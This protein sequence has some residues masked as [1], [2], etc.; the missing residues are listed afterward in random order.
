MCRC[1]VGTYSSVSVNVFQ[2]MCVFVCI[3]VAVKGDGKERSVKDKG[4][5]QPVYCYVVIAISI[6]LLSLT[7]CTKPQTLASHAQKKAFILLLKLQYID[8]VIDIL[9]LLSPKIFEG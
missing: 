2:H 8:E 3:A 4:T 9:S 5:C 1:G 6:Q 7:L